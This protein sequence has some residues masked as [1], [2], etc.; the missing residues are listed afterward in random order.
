M[1]HFH[2]TAYQ[3]E[4]M[5]DLLTAMNT[6]IDHTIVLPPGD[7]DRELLLPVLRMQ[8]EKM[9]KMRAE[10]QAEEADGDMTVV[11]VCKYS[12]DYCKEK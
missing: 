7:W 5:R 10:M 1:Q 9:K 3:A 12:L 8:H 4:S 11:D 6:F 2:E